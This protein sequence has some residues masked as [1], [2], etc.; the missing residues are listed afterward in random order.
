MKR[1]WLILALLALA[2]F[3]Y[4]LI[5]ISLQ[6]RVM[7]P[8]VAFL[9]TKQHAY[10]I[11]YWRASFYTHVFSS[12]LV[13]LA[14]FTQ[15]AP[16]L[17]R[18]RPAVHR[19]M[20]WIYLVVVLVIS[21]PAAFVMAL[22]ANGGLAGRISFTLLAGL[23]LIFTFLAGYF[24]V[25]RQFARHGAFMILS[26]A[27]TLSAITLRGYEWLIYRAHPH[28]PVRDIYALTSWLSWVPNLIVALILIVNEAPASLFSQI[29]HQRQSGR[30]PAVKAPEA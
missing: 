23:W 21:G 1:V 7:R 26:Y 16:W 27:L 25:R 22:Y 30:L 2:F 19:I 13:L 5:R 11:G 29:S 28:V 20:G 15:F 9:H 17:L 10:Y 8:N 4:L 14:G 12:W 3:S 6:Y 18:R 24:V